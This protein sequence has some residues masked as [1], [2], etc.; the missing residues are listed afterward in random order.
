MSHRIERLPFVGLL[1]PVLT[2]LAVASATSTPDHLLL[3]LALAGM[4]VLASSAGAA[5]LQA[6]VVSVRHRSQVCRHTGVR[7]TD[8][9]HSGRVRPRAPGLAA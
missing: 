3:G 8:P 9:D 7:S 5:P 6:R 2:L 4:A 1:L